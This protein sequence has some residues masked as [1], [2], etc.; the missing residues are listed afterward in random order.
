[1]FIFDA[2]LTDLSGICRPAALRLWPK[3]IPTKD[4]QSRS[5]ALIFKKEFQT[6]LWEGLTWVNQKS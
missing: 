1:M 3:S 4:K 2:L 5:E 6:L